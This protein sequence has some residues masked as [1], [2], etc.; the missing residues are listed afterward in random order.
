MLCVRSGKFYLIFVVLKSLFHITDPLGNFV[1]KSSHNNLIAFVL[2]RKA[3]EFYN[4]E[5]TETPFGP[6]H[7]CAK[8]FQKS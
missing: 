6:T 1:I 5:E 3:D 8:T 4:W 7:L 2:N